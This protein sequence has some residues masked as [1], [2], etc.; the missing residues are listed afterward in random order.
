QFVN[1]LGPAFAAVARIP[2]DF[3][4]SILDLG[5]FGGRVEAEFEPLFFERSSERLGHLAIGGGKTSVEKFQ[6]EDFA[7]EAIPYAAELKADVAG[8]DDDQSRRNVGD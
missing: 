3:D 1:L 5:V 6:H 2:G 4:L 8:A 7:A